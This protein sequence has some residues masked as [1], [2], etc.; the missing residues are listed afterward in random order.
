M[1]EL[2]SIVI[3]GASLAGLRAAAAARRAGFKGRLTLIGAETHLPYDRPPLSKQILLGQWEPARTVLTTEADLAKLDLDLRLGRRAVSLDTAARKVALDDETTA[4]YDALIIA[5]GATPRMIPGTPPLAGIH[6]LR[7]V[8]DSLAIRAAMEAG[9][10]V[11]VV[12]MGFIGAE[13]AAA[14]RQRGLPT[15]VVEVFDHPLQRALGPTAG[16][17]AV[18]L[19]DRTVLAVAQCG[20]G[21][22]DSTGCELQPCPSKPSTSSER[23]P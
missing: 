23:D 15:T 7:T 6:V 19:D 4:V 8:E 21:S 17:A 22:N 16:A 10:R 11:A 18:I 12:G 20:I 9:A 2:N 3:V 5:T 1:P 13:V 14:A